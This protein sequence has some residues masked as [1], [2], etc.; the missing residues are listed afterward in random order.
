MRIFVER[1]SEIEKDN[2]NVFSIVE[3]LLE[4]RDGNNKLCF[5]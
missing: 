2:V 1:F 5:T 3:A 4:V